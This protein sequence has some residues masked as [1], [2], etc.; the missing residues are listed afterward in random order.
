MI[1]RKDKQFNQFYAAHFITSI[2]IILVISTDFGLIR[3]SA[4][5]RGGLIRDP[6]SRDI[7]SC[8]HI[9]RETSHVILLLS[10]KIP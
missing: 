10:P 3:G 2:A 8:D 4:D 9:S 5:Q 6:R 1:F 7:G